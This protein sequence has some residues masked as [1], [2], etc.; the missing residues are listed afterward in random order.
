LEEPVAENELSNYDEVESEDDAKL[1]QVAEDELSE[2]GEDTSEADVDALGETVKDESEGHDMV[3]NANNQDAPTDVLVEPVVKDESTHSDEDESESES[4]SED[5]DAQ[6]N[7]DEKKD[8]DNSAVDSTSFSKLLDKKKKK[9][10]NKNAH[11]L[12]EHD[13]DHDNSDHDDSVN[14]LLPQNKRKSSPSIL[15]STGLGFSADKQSE[16]RTVVKS[17][18]DK[19]QFSAA[20]EPDMDLYCLIFW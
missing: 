19:E 10:K 14:E 8:D 1:E 17:A 7:D 16:L 2:T 20:F 4:E 5:D 3:E 18:A 6:V 11:D 13:D 12:S 9:K 15:F